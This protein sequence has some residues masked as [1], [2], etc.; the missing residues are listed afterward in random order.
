MHPG[1]FGIIDLVTRRPV[2]PGRYA[3]GRSRRATVS[4]VTA[5]S[6]T[7][8]VHRCLGGGPEP[9]QLQAVV[10]H[11]DDNPA[12]DGAQH[13]APPAEQAGPADDRGGHGV[14]DVLPPWTLLE[15][16]PR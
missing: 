2:G 10:D 7:A 5:A 13:L 14:Q 11:G 9:E 4:T 1:P 6:R 15:T 16:E 12:K 3:L 8:A